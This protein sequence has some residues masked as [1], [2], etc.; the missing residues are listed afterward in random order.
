MI[1]IFLILLAILCF[2]LKALILH[3]TTKLFKVENTKYKT[4]LLISVIE[5]IITV[6]AVVA[7]LLFSIVVAGPDT[8]S[9][10]SI[11]EDLLLLT[12]NLIVFHKLLGKYYQTKLKKNIGIYV[13][14]VIFTVILSFFIIVP[15]RSFVVEP[16]VVSGMAMEPTLENLEYTLIKKFDKNYERGDIVVFQDPQNS[17]EYLI[18]RIVG[19][20]NE[21]IQIKN[22]KVYIY[23]S[24]NSDGFELKEEYLPKESETFSLSKDLIDIGNDGYYVLGDNREKSKDSRV[25]GLVNKDLILG[26]YWFSVNTLE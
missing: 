25:F 23:N 21:K 10:V 1:I 19:L 6:V 24:E 26:K 7:I 15:V 22:K 3:I 13:V 11:I 8:L 16:F 4:A 20:P 14:S 18:K 2:L 17:Q 5:I 9:G 12:V